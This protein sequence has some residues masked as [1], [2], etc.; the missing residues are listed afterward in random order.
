VPPLSPNAL[1]NRYD[2]A[3]YESTRLLA[4][5]RFVNAIADVI[6]GPD[7]HVQ[8]TLLVRVYAP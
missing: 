3:S 5:Y 4:E 1:I 2:L 6:D 8:R 7:G